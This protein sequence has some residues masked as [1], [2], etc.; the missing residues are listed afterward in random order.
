LPFAVPTSAQRALVGPFA[1]VEEAAGLC[2][3]LKAAWRQLHRPKKLTLARLK[4]RFRA[5]GF[6]A[7]AAAKAFFRV[8]EHAPPLKGA[9][10]GR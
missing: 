2:N 1:S 8:I 4:C 9:F 3:R 5:K 6:L 7:R 10:L